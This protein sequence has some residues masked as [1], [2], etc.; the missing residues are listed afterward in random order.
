[1]LSNA[2][3]NLVCDD[4]PALANFDIRKMEGTWYEQQ[5]TFSQ[6]EKNISCSVSQLYDM[7][8][9]ADDAS[10]VSYKVYGS[11]Q[12]EVFGHWTPRTGMN[13]KGKC[14]TD[15]LC[16]ISYFGKSVP[17]PNLTMVDTDY[18]SY[19][20]EY[21]CDKDQGVNMLWLLTRDLNPTEEFF[22]E[23]TAKAQKLLPNFD[24]STLD[25]R[26]YQ[27]EHCAEVKPRTSGA[28]FFA[29]VEDHLAEFT[30]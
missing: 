7:E 9:D 6:H 1:M 15:G 2:A 8:T 13:S 27:G 24:W 3:S 5:H 16:Y 4:P 12:T 17:E 23:I 14:G 22:A 30:Q 25:K 28:G 29:G 10:L 21:S 19:S 20:I 18:T 26:V 11:F